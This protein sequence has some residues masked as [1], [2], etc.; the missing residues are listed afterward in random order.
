[1]AGGWWRERTSWLVFAI[2]NSISLA[3]L[4]FDPKPHVFLVIVQAII[5]LRIVFFIV[6]GS[7]SYHLRDLVVFTVIVVAISNFFEN[8]SILTG[9]PFGEYYYTDGLGPKIFLVPIIITPAYLT[10]GYL[11]WVTAHMLFYTP[12]SAPST[13]SVTAIPFI[14]SILMVSWDLTMDPFMSTSSKFWVWKKGG[15]YFGVP[16]VNFLGWFLTVYLIFLCFALYLR[17]QAHSNNEPNK[18]VSKSF[19][20]VAIVSYMFIALQTLFDA[21]KRNP[22]KTFVDPTGAFSL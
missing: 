17:S 13:P 6:H 1:M 22:E 19:W 21:A 20:V 3:L 5:S 4:F 2:V 8:L 12:A 9:F 14:A 7:L 10:T 11:S 16:F 15:S 18:S